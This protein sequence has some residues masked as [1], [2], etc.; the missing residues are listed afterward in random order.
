[1]KSD[2]KN[3]S[4]LQFELWSDFCL[5]M[6]VWKVRLYFKWCSLFGSPQKVYMAFM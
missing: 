3:H 4:H 2:F 5:N 1:M 6:S